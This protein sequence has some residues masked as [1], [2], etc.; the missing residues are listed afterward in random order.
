MWRLQHGE[1]DGLNPKLVVLMIGTNNLY[2]DFNS[3]SDAEIAQA[4]KAIMTT[5]R[6]KMPRTRI[7]LMGLL[8]RQNTYFSN[9]V[10]AIN[11][12]IAPLDDGKMVRFLDIGSKFQTA[13]GVVRPELYFPDQLHPKEEGYVVWADAMQPLFDKM[14]AGKD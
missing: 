9:R 6:A 12:L 8:P 11:R 5:L 13:V 14:R 10:A 1:I 3:G 2:G 7:L 4:I